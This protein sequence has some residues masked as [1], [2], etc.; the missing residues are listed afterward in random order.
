M[1]KTFRCSS[2]APALITFKQT[3]LFNIL[4]FGKKMRPITVNQYNRNSFCATSC[5]YRG[6]VSRHSRVMISP[7]VISVVVDSQSSYSWF[8]D[9]VLIL[10]TR[11]QFIHTYSYTWFITLWLFW[12]FTPRCLSINAGCSIL[13]SS[14]TELY[15]LGLAGSPYS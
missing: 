15:A 4:I 12:D 3:V 10:R 13:T 14:A 1:P 8:S 5:L 7:R 9:W 6:T 2:Q 11:H